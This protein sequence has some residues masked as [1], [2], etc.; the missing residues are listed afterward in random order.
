M[1]SDEVEL[2]PSVTPN[3]SPPLQ[4]CS[5]LPRDRHFV[6]ANY[7]SLE[8]VVSELD[9]AGKNPFMKTRLSMSARFLRKRRCVVGLA[10]AC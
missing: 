5:D 9:E 4:H 10:L 6:E 8:K 2:T 1:C 7:Q 3:P